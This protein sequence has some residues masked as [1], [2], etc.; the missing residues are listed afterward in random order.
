MRNVQL[1]H[2][3]YTLVLLQPLAGA[4]SFFMN[5]NTQER[6][7]SHPETIITAI[8]PGAHETQRGLQLMRNVQLLTLLIPWYFY[9]PLLGY[10]PSLWTGIHKNEAT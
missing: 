7:N 4:K 2:A 1:L 3:P 9:N 5:R 8:V 10:R 6:G